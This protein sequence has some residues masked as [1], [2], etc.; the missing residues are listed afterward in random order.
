MRLRSLVMVL[1][2][3]CLLLLTGGPVSL[4]Q[5]PPQ[6]QRSLFQLFWQL[7]ARP[8]VQPQQP[9]LRPSPAPVV[10]RSRAAAPVVVRD[11][12]VIPKV[13]VTN[14][15]V[16]MGDSLANLLADGLDEAL[17]DRPDVEVTHRTKPDSGLVR[18]DFYDWQKAVT[19]LLASDQKITIAVMMV[20]LNDRQPIR[21]GDIVQE[22]LSPRWLELYRDRVDALATA[23]AAKR[24]PLIWVGVPPVQ[25]AR[26]SA[27]LVTLN[28]LYRER[29]EKAGG[30]Y[31]DL[32]GGFVDSENR[33]TA[34]G[35]DVSGQPTRLRL[36]DGVHFTK[37]GARKAAHFVDLVIRRIIEQAPQS[38]VIALPVAPD[39]GAPTAPEL[40]PGGVERLIDQMAAGLPAIGLPQA[41]QARPLA[42][43]I[44]PLTGQ[45]A[46]SAQPLLASITE[47]RGRGDAA[48]QLE[49][50]FGQ[51]IAPEP[52]PGR[53]DDYRW[54][55]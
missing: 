49:R 14:H 17:N 54:P 45:A 38:N 20:G 28:E 9:R 31:V 42:G 6:Q 51:G 39:T 26:L 1:C 24:I 18:T 27:D 44:Q 43:P 52:V 19:D 4:A 53:I 34:T 7:P 5:Q 41:L 25:N 2:S 37:A 21:E 8:A 35:P 23:F 40:Q 11:D 46:P 22:P 15:I 10:R 47:A 32:W 3:A 12:P 50:V 16:V 13:D 33:Y 36:G 30:Q 29:A 48:D 55:R